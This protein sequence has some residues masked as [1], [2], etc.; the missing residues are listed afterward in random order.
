[1][2]KLTDMLEKLSRTENADEFR[3]LREVLEPEILRT[4]DSVL[5]WRFGQVYRQRQMWPDSERVL[6]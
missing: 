5:L 4:H 6:R 3:Q 2:N 1:M